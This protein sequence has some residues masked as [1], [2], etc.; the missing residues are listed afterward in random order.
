VHAAAIVLATASLLFQPQ[1]ISGEVSLLTPANGATVVYSGLGTAPAFAWR[2]DWGDA[3]GN[4]SVVIVLRTATDPALTQNAIE[5]TF[6]CRVRDV[7]CTTSF[8]PNRVYQGAYYWRVTVAGSVRATSETWSFTGV[9]RGAGRGTSDRAKPRVQSIAGVAQRGQTAFFGARAS[10]DSGVVRLRAA[11]LRRG[12]EVARAS[13]A[14]RAVTWRHKQTL[15]SS[16]PLSRGLVAG[17]YTLCVTAWD[18]AGRSARDC[19][20]YRLR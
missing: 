19:A 4:G 1:A 20:A 11:L 18:R 17:A 16:R 15:F 10:D 7:N 5:N 3:S 9:K 8:R 14:F 13:A 6:S 2:I 12:H